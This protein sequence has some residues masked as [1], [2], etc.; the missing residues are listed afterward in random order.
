MN[1]HLQGHKLQLLIRKLFTIGLLFCFLP[2][3]GQDPEIISP[4]EPLSFPDGWVGIWKGE[5]NIFNQNGFQ[6]S[7]LMQLHIQPLDSLGQYS[8]TIIYGTDL[9][10][11]SRPYVLNTIDAE[12][13]HYEIDE[14]NSIAME[15][16][17]LHDKLFNRFTVM[18]NLLLSSTEMRDGQLVFE[19]ISGSLVAA[20]QTGD[21]VVDGEKI[22]PVATLPVTVLQRAVL[23]RE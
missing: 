5:L 6:Q 19:I 20:S 1:L 3:W 12:K 17:F 14:R 18:D 7:L 9:E 2:L 10:A 22:P 13:G 8:W 15:A 21:T 16:Y 23:T 4:K 11:G